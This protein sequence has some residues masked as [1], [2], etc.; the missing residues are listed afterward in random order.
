MAASLWKALAPGALVAGLLVA[1]F[2]MDARPERAR[3]EPALS[4][5]AEG[6]PAA[7]L[8]IA[9]PGAPPP[10]ARPT[11]SAPR[12]APAAPPESAA[13]DPALALDRLLRW[14]DSQAPPGLD[15]RPGREPAAAAQ[16]SGGAGGGTSVYLRRRSETHGPAARE[17]ALDE[18]EVGVR[19][20]V[21]ASVDLR[22]GVRVDSR[23]DVRTGERESKT[24]P[25]VGVEVR[26]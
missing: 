9:T 18:T 17:Q 12:P 24:T 11:A 16:A 1:L 7:E 4:G 15:L 25:T 23:E 8:P 22:G 19:V 10:P 3:P 14:S 2:R 20:P 21:D 13:A 5:G 6:P 26:F